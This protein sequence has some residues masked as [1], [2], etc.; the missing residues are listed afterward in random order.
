MKKENGEVKVLQKG[1]FKYV[2][3][4]DSNAL[5]SL[6]WILNFNTFFI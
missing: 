2:V 3:V 4:C 6:D 5:K 1:R